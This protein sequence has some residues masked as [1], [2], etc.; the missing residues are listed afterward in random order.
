MT[1]YYGCTMTDGSKCRGAWP[2]SPRPSVFLAVPRGGQRRPRAPFLAPFFAELFFAVAGALEPAGA[3]AVLAPPAAGGR[4]AER[5]AR[6]TTSGLSSSSSSSTTG[7]PS[8][9]SSSS[10]ESSVLSQRSS[11]SSLWVVQPPSSSSSSS[12]DDEPP[13][14]YPRSSTSSSRSEN[15]NSSFPSSPRGITASC[16]DRKVGPANRPGS[17]ACRTCDP[18]GGALQNVCPASDRHRHPSA[19]P[20]RV[21]RRRLRVHGHPCKA[22]RGIR[23]ADSARACK[24]LA[25]D[26]V[27][28]RRL[29]SARERRPAPP[30][31]AR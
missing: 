24:S 29:E 4:P 23:Q 19:S 10:S 30:Q 15:L 11:L 3:P 20:D 25:L 28:R 27:S 7:V 9:S 16:R 14:P 21:S 5:G 6:A 13:P 31:V 22:A 1:G 17:A 12:Y 26:E 2:G 18:R 8:P